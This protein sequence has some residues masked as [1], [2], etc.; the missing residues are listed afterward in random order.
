MSGKDLIIIKWLRP[1]AIVSK[2]SHLSFRPLYAEIS[3][4][5]SRAI[6]NLAPCLAW[7]PCQRMYCFSNSSTLLF[8]ARIIL[9]YCALSKREA[10]VDYRNVRDS[11]RKRYGTVPWST[12]MYFS[13]YLS[14]LK[15]LCHGVSIKYPNIY[16]SWKYNLEYSP[17]G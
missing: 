16:S 5:A 3:H 12:K 6:N 7:H 13:S 15:P 8:I 10:I 9:C 17:L 1:Q 14:L 2:K 11:L 4:P